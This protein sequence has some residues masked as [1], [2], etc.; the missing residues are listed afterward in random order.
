MR[1]AQ[2]GFT[3]IELMVTLALAAI[4]LMAAVPSFTQIIKSNRLTTNVND[5]V[6]AISLARSEALKSGGASVCA[7][8]DGTACDNALWKQGWIVFTD[9]NGDCVVDAGEQ[10]VKAFDAVADINNIQSLQA[11]K[12]VSYGSNGYLTAGNGSLAPVAGIQR[13]F[14]FC[15]DRTDANA[16]RQIN[17]NTAGRP[18]TAV[19]GGCPVSSN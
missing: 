16:G 2:T 9:L 1:K 13:D 3:I 19:Y 4:V 7:S 17:I 8:S 11:I 14:L 18:A 12:C 5:L 10:V 6:Y 15:D